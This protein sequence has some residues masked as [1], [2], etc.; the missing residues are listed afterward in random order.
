MQV[1]PNV[2]VDKDSS[3]DEFRPEVRSISG[4]IPVPSRW[5]RNP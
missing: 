4:A 1:R 3:W 2:K 5:L